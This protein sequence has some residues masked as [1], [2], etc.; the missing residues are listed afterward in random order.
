M[1]TN[2][3]LENKY[4]VVWKEEDDEIVITDIY[5]IHEGKKIDITSD[6]LDIRL[7]ADFWKDKVEAAINWNQL[8]VCTK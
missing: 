4:N 1:S 8:K 7:S 5:L 3:F 2:I 6:E